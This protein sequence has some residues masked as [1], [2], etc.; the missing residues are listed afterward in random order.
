MPK[1]NDAIKT[2]DSD[3]VVEAKKA[4]APVV[5]VRPASMYEEGHIPGALSIPLVVPEDGSMTR[6][7]RRPGCCHRRRHLPR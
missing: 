3:R 5:D 1:E 4:G 2:I 6:R 7:R